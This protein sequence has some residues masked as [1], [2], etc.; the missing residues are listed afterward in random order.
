MYYFIGL[1]AALGTWSSTV[2]L[3]RCLL[4]LGHVR[5]LFLFNLL[6]CRATTH[7]W[8]TL[9]VFL[10]R[11][12]H[13]LRREKLH[14]LAG[15]ADFIR[16]ATWGRS[17]FGPLIRSITMSWYALKRTCFAGTLGSLGHHL[18]QLT[19][20]FL[21]HHGSDLFE[22][23]FHSQGDFLVHN[24]VNSGTGCTCSRT[25][26]ILNLRW[27]HTLGNQ[28]PILYKYRLF[29][30]WRTW[31]NSCVGWILHLIFDTSNPILLFVRSILIFRRTWW[32]GWV[33]HQNLCVLVV[34]FYL[35]T[36]ILITKFQSNANYQNQIKYILFF[37]VWYSILEHFH[38]E[39]FE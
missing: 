14:L 25:F 36:K 20:H 39:N 4:I 16:I 24:I 37:I 13:R 32:I 28:A 3:Y 34:Y 18:T 31:L 26:G 30:G 29:A 8:G 19:S 17:H 2:C 7:P 12:R 5:R 6:Y 27:R 10:W 35:E 23:D 33:F 15:T 9:Y 11:G 21:L 1:Y 22:H 38:L